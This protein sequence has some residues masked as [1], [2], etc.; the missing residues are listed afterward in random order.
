GREGWGHQT[1]PPSPS[2]APPTHEGPVSRETEPEPPLGGRWPRH[3][4]KAEPLERALELPL[5]RFRVARKRGLETPGE[6]N[7]PACSRGSSRAGPACAALFALCP[8]AQ[9]DDLF[10]REWMLPIALDELSRASFVGS[11]LEA[12]ELGSDLERDVLLFEE[13]Q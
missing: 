13:G 12:H 2:T 3:Q 9:K 7:M 4:T 1:R 11:F 6:S 8:L 10:A 5:R